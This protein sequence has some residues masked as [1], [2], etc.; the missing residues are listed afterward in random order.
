MIPRNID[1]L[2]LVHEKLAVSDPVI[3]PCKV[4]ALRFITL[5]DYTFKIYIV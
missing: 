1:Q 2:Y 3:I 4:I 5:V